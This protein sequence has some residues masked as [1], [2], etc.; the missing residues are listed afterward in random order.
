[1]VLVEV[2]TRTPFPPS[3]LLMPENIGSVLKVG[4]RISGGS[5]LARLL[6]LERLFERTKEACV[7]CSAASSDVGGASALVLTLRTRFK[8]GI[9]LTALFVRK[10]GSTGE[11]GDDIDLWRGAC[12]GFNAGADVGDDGSE[13]LLFTSRRRGGRGGG[14]LNEGSN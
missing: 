7:S 2:C 11:T 5:V 4:V 12:V 1:M 8:R 6:T 13:L 14:A 10:V 3:S 9:A